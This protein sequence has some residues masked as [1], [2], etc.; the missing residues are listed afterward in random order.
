MDF[1]CFVDKTVNVRLCNEE[2]FAAIV[3]DVVPVFFEYK[4][5]VREVEFGDVT[6]TR[7]A[8][9]PVR[10]NN[11][12]VFFEIANVFPLFVALDCSTDPP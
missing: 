2:F 8:E 1:G 10:K 12:T 7:P 5:I 4:S 6:F 9:G 3:T 11:V